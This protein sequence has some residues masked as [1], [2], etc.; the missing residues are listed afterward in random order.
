MSD[1]I[2][3][4]FVMELIGTA[5]F[6][7]SGAMAAIRKNLDLLGI[8]VL[9]VI[10]AVGGG[11]IRDVLIGIHPPTLFIKPVYVTVAVIAAIAMFLAMH[12]RHLSR[13]LLEAEYYDWT[14][15]LL[16]AIGLGAFTVVGVNT[17]A[18]RGYANYF[19]LTI[20]LGVIT[21]VG[22]GLLRDMMACEVPAILKKH[23]YAC[24]SIAGALCYAI[25]IDYIATDAA[26][27]ISA[28]LVI[29]LRLLARHYEWN[30]PRCNTD[31]QKK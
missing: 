15:N 24:A 10:T 28:A 31:Y 18:S 5:A 19:F 21:G 3:V 25:I 8:I 30:L 22:G 27:I 6:S 2:T 1:N 29:V 11:M 9:G 23:I 4:L 16:D 20:F 17:A 26:L 13:F 7:C 14:M 12:S